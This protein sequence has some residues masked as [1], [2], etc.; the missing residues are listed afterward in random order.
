MYNNPAAFQI[1]SFN[2]QAGN[3][4]SS[5]KLN[6]NAISSS[7][8]DVPHQAQPADGDRAVDEEGI[9]EKGVLIDSGST[10][11]AVIQPEVSV[12]EVGLIEEVSMMADERIANIIG[13]LTSFKEELEDCVATN[14]ETL[15]SISEFEELRKEIKALKSNITKSKTVLQ[16]LKPDED[17]REYD[18]AVQESRTFLTE[19]ETKR[20]TFI[21]NQV[22]KDDEKTTSHMSA[23]KSSLDVMIKT[24]NIKYTMKLSDLSDGETILLSDNMSSVRE[25]H[26]D[27]IKLYHEFV[28]KCPTNYTNRMKL[29]TDYH[30][31]MNDIETKKNEYEQGIMKEMQERELTRNKIQDIKNE[32]KLPFFLGYESELDY[33]SFKSRFLNKYR[34]YTSRDMLD[35]LKNSY[36]KGEAFNTVKE[37]TNIE[38]VWTRLKQDFGNPSRMLKSKLSDVVK[39]ASFGKIKNLASKSEAVLKTINLLS[40]IFTLAEEHKLQLEL[41]CKN[42]KVLGQML[43]QLPRLW[44]HDWQILK[45]NSQEEISQSAMNAAAWKQDQLHWELFKTFLNEQLLNL[46]DE[47]AIED[48]L[49]EVSI[50][51]DKGK[52]RKPTNLSSLKC[53]AGAASMDYYEYEDI[54]E[55]SPSPM[56]Q[57]NVNH[58]CKLC[59]LLQH[60]HYWDCQT[61]MKSKHG[62]RFELFVNPRKNANPKPHIGQLLGECAACLVPNSKFGHDCHLND[63][64]V[65]KWICPGQH[66]KPVNF[67]CCRHHIDDNQKLWEEFHFNTKVGFVQ[68]ED[69]IPVWKI[70]MEWTVHIALSHLCD[71]NSNN[72]NSSPPLP[73]NIEKPVKDDAIF[74][75]QTIN[76]DNEIYNMFFDLG[77]GDFCA[78]RNAVQKLKDRATLLRKGPFELVGAGNVVTEIKHGVY[79]VRLPLANGNEALFAGLCLNEVTAKFCKY[80]IKPLYDA[81][82]DDFVQ[83]GGNKTSFPMLGSTGACGGETD[84][85]LGIKYNRYQ[86]KVIHQLESGLTVYESAFLGVDGSRVVVGGPHPLVSEIE[87]QCAF[88]RG[89][90]IRSHFSKQLQLYLNGY[91]ISPDSKIKMS[92]QNIEFHQYSN[93]SFSRFS[94]CE[95]AGTLA[96]YRCEACRLCNDCKCGPQL[97][98]VSRREVHEQSVINESVIFNTEQ[99]RVE[100]TLPLMQDPAKVLGNNDRNAKRVYQRW[101]TKLNKNPEDLKS[102]IRSENKLQTRGHVEFLKNLTPEQQKMIQGSPYKYIFPWRPVYN[103]NSLTTPARLTFDGGDKTSTGVSLNDIL[104]KGINQI[105]S[106]LEILISWRNGRFAMASDIEQMYNGIKLNEKHWPL[107]LYFWNDELKVDMEPELKV[108][109]TVTYGV[110][111]SGNQAIVGVKLVAEHSKEEFPEAHQTL[112]KQI[113]IDDVLPKPKHDLEECH[114]LADELNVV[115]E[116]G[117]LK[118]KSFS[119]TSIPPDP[120]VSSDGTSV[121]VAGMKWNTVVD[122]ISLTTGSINFSKK[123][124]GKKSIHPDSFKVPSTLTQRICTSVVG[125]IWD[126]FGQIV[127]ITAR[128]KLDLHELVLRKFDWDDEIPEELKKIWVENFELIEQL[129]DVRFKRATV[130]Q[131]A[132]DLNMELI[133]AGDASSSLICVGIYVRFKR[134]CGKYSCELVVGKSKIVPN[135]MSVPRGEVYAAEINSVLGEV[136]MR[137]LGDHVVKRFKITDSKVA[138]YWIH[139]WEK[140]L[141]LWTRNR[142]NEILRWSKVEWW[143]WCPSTDMPC[144]IGTRRNATV[145]DVGNGSQWKE[146]L[147]WM[148]EYSSQF[149]LKTLSEIQLEAEERLACEKEITPNHSTYSTQYKDSTIREQIQKRLIFSN[150]IIHPN[151]YRLRSVVTVLALVF[152]FLKRI[153]S[154]LNHPLKCLQVSNKHRFKHFPTSLDQKDFQVNYTM[155]GKDQNKSEIS[156][157]VVLNENEIDIALRYLY[158]KATHEIEQF[159]QNRKAFKN[160]VIIDGIRYYTGRLLPS[161]EFSSPDL[162]PMSVTMTDLSSNTFC[163]PLVD[164]F[165]PIA[166]SLTF[167]IHWYDVL[168]S[169]TG[170]AT[171]ARRVKEFAHVVGVKGIAEVFRKSCGKC[172]AIAKRTVEVAFGPLSEYQLTIIAPAFYVTQADIMGPFKA[173]QINVRATMKIWFA[174]FVCVATST[175]DIQVMEFY[176]SGS[177]I[178]ALIRFASRNG[179]PKIILPDQGSNIENAI[180]NVE[181]NWI[182]VKGQL[183]KS[184]GIDL[185]TCGVGGHH[186]HG[187]VER[188][189]RHIKETYMKTVH[190][191]RI[192]VLQWQTVADETANCIN[193]LPIGTGSSRNIN[194][195]LDDLDIIT[196]NRLR[197]GRNNERSPLGP[198]YLSHDPFKF[199]DTNIKIFNCWWEHWLLVVAPELIEKPVNWKSGDNVKVG[200]VVL[201]RK[202]E[203]SVGPGTYQYGIILSVDVSADGVV[204]NAKVKYRNADEGKDRTTDRNVKS[205]ILI[206]KVD[207]L[208]I[209][210]EMFDASLYVDKL[211]TAGADTRK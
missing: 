125:E 161:Q 102:I 170:I 171:T 104:P 87:K 182:D 111:S 67:L 162:H 109:K 135:G 26:N 46:K 78:S 114:K 92:D 209:M 118:L 188:K 147:Q 190:K 90:S 181:I 113:Y 174:V 205:L 30:S 112:T 93:K 21:D 18:T 115:V 96:N 198:A 65:K 5:D 166:W 47:E 168:V 72:N 176:S 24:C 134:K 99:K 81:V 4:R 42:E 83:K 89:M 54:D 157:A 75:L 100:C 14:L 35:I 156:F 3:R 146:G 120:S 132:V 163:V 155:K 7:V 195:E 12:E 145:N 141:K 13:D 110:R 71:N 175:V 55:Q 210:K 41:Y 95:D 103:Q 148:H 15:R 153:S 48:A 172:R 124:R 189:I 32:I 158:Q 173:Y 53:P 143:Y 10:T 60:R 177:F 74:L 84:I 142:V 39:S 27:L 149:P 192:S 62:D 165:S 200:D 73:A 178:A 29:L 2:I 94:S 185:K 52:V 117:G 34:R 1:S 28:E 57:T 63:D 50:E 98:E 68:E 133:E 204:R 138:L 16:R 44:L 106:L 121:S 123:Y 116:R 169:H 85:M 180:H 22:K 59:K 58:L 37:L 105:N 179:Y 183:H 56:F 199:M 159:G 207:E 8:D 64:N 208:D 11:E 130:P 36:L 129:K 206:H 61:F 140:P 76:V 136:V 154:P 77:C 203:G 88:V 38:D 23:L 193:N 137:A 69:F 31:T 17:I 197:F 45:K 194:L 80:N 119:F 186:Q 70:N 151:K 196:P 122:D 160:S 184:Y 187:K 191:E 97:E 128:L 144:D 152:R 6:T 139:A 40:D 131:D 51:D 33:Y 25:E 101:V 91:D 79:Q 126:L 19:L 43:K 107:Q 150:Y 49:Q 86:P 127:P 66:K 9:P 201:F 108:I 202:S 211:R 164:Q 82:L 167:E 20:L